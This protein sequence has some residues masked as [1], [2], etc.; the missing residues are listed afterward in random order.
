MSGDLLFDTPWW[1]PVL[2]VAIGVFVFVSGNQRQQSGTRNIGAGIIF[3][4][5][6]IVLLTIFVDT[7]RKSPA[8]S[9]SSSYSRR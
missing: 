7:P 4:A 9:R 8:G 2:I 1:L 3:L 5:V 6:V